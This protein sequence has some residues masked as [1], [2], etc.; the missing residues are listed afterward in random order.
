VS[1]DVIAATDLAGRYATALFELADAD[2][3]LEAVSG[4]LETIGAMIEGSD[5]LTR[6][7]R[8][9]VISRED[10]SRAMDAV[11][12]AAEIGELTQKFIGVVAANR[13]L[14]ALPS[15]IKSFVK[16]LADRRGETTAEVV[17]ASELSDSQLNAVK[18]SLKKAMGVDVAIDAKVDEE[19]LGGLVV[20]VGSRMVDS[21][22]K[23]KLDQLRFAMKGIG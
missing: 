7:I 21:S 5:D 3:A 22:L 2:N 19:I 8:S 12:E 16:L 10:Q 11:L 6:L 14:F 13:R 20:R 9:P 4:D 18:N 15:M 17:S 1:S 23:T